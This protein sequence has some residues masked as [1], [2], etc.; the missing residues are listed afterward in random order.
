M[1]TATESS[2]EAR[3]I[4]RMSAVQPNDPRLNGASCAQ[5]TDAD[6][7]WPFDTGAAWAAA[8]DA[9]HYVQANGGT[10]RAVAIRVGDNG[11]REDHREE[12][13]LSLR[14][15]NRRQ[16]SA[17][18]L[19][20]HGISSDGTGNVEP[21]PP[22]SEWWHGAEVA[23]LA[24]GGPAFWQKDPPELGK[25]IKVTFARLFDAGG[26]STVRFR[27][28]VLASSLEAWEPRPAVL[29]LSI[30][31]PVPFVGFDAALRQAV[32]YRQVLVVAAGNEARSL[33][34]YASYPALYARDHPPL[35]VVGAHDRR[36]LLLGFSNYGRE[37]VHLLA[38]GC[39]LSPKTGNTGM[40]KLTGTS[41]AAPLVSFTAAMLLSLTAH[42]ERQSVEVRER[43][44]ITARRLMPENETAVAYGI[45]DVP[46]A[47][48][49]YDD[50]LRLIDGRLLHGNW[51]HDDERDKRTLETLCREKN[52][53]GRDWKTISLDRVARVRVHQEEKRVRLRLLIRERSTSRL[54]LWEDECEPATEGLSFVEAQGKP[55]VRPWR[56]IA[57]LMPARNFWDRRSV[58]PTPNVALGPPD[59]LP[60]I[61]MGRLSREGPMILD[62]VGRALVRSR[63]APENPTSAQQRAAIEAFQAMRREAITGELT[64]A[65]LLDLNRIHMP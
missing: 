2:G 52:G 17:G 38:P 40:P 37:H 28:G 3:D 6:A 8:Q 30:G 61:V 51:K 35:L 27:E 54:P 49:L 20:E 32:G 14:F 29:N 56:D 31:S 4:T 44:R 13:P 21:P 25:R 5:G 39:G 36:G 12:I 53:D 34:E 60:Y 47:L 55:E 15:Q 62:Q 48:R 64:R 9:I 10:L 45:L 46:A 16:T 11:I 26:G 42:S 43:L 59:S 18:P 63:L 19:I 41:F 65:Q 58:G 1:V 22:D 24:L 57:D 7:S 33:S 50:V 23:H